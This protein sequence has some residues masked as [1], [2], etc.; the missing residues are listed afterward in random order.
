MLSF[1]AGPQDLRHAGPFALHINVATILSAEFLRFDA[2]LP[3][4]LRGQVILNLS[5]P[6]IMADAAAFTFARNFARSRGY[7]LLLR[8]A[9]PSLLS[10]LDVAAAELDLIEV[11]L[12]PALRADPDQLL[13][14][15]PDRV[16]ILLTG[17][18]TSTE[19]E[20]A[21]THHFALLAGRAAANLV[22]H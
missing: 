1:L 16:A 15:V 18:D 9:T 11:P 22:T 21:Q 10:L 19:L 6:D 13:L 20:W 5:A 2:A 14:V 3:G 8:G 7:R 4:A 17:V 12:T